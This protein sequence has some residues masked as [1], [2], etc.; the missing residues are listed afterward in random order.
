MGPPP[1]GDGLTGGHPVC[2]ES[3]GGGGE[4]CAGVVG[5]TQMSQGSPGSVVKG[6]CHLPHIPIPSQ[7]LWRPIKPDLTIIVVINR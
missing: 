5:Q 6:P 4:V 1:T 7:S 3:H 2:D